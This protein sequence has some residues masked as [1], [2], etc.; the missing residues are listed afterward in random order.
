M[1]C[2]NIPI[3]YAHQALYLA[4]T[5]RPEIKISNLVQTVNGYFI[6]DL[7]CNKTNQEYDLFIIPKKQKLTTIDNLLQQGGL[8]HEPHRP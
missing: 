1:S 3:H 2:E 8:P 4:S 7:K 5:S 6:A